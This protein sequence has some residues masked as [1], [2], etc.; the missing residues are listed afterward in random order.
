MS[1]KTGQFDE[2]LDSGALAKL[3][4]D[5]KGLF[6]SGLSVP[7]EVDRAVMDRARQRLVRRGRRLSWPRWAR[8]WRVAVAAA[9]V[10]VLAVALETR[11]SGVSNIENK[12]DVRVSEAVVARVRAD[13][14][15]NG[16]VDILDAFKLA[17]HIESAGAAGAVEAKWDFNGDGLVNRKD[18]D[19]VAFAAVRLDKGV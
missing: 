15:L 3:S 13:I 14:D 4:E 10:I 7:G 16:R 19:T 12:S 17:R 18:V 1:D 6:E 8:R 9:A 5:L 2:G 11:F